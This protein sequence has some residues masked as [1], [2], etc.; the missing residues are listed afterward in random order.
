M[1][2]NWFLH[3]AVRHA[4][5]MRKHVRKLVSAQRDLLKPVA[6][7]AMDQALAELH[8]AEHGAVDGDLL[9]DRMAKVEAAANK[10]LRPYPHAGFR[11]NIEVLLVAI[12]VAMGI[13]T[14]VLQPFK[15]PTGS[16]QPTLYG[17]TDENLIHQP[18]TPIPHRLSPGRFFDF[19]FNGV[20][21]THM[22]AAGDGR[23]EILDDNPSRFLLFNLKQRFSIGGKIQT[24][25]FPPEKLWERAG[26][27][28][29]TGFSATRHFKTGED[30]I[31][32]R[33]VSGDHLFVDRMTYNF[34]R[35]R[36]GEI[37]VFETR[38]IRGLPQDQY[39]NKRMVAMDG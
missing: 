22:V 27:R 36:R 7:E 18:D 25:W 29:P 12:A 37:I 21:Y 33:T 3:R 9:K 5:Q 23:F 11:E 16:M 26:L 14:F 30:V 32:L 34:R 28:D 6:I 35:P 15:I 2:L 20:G 17:I 19:W 10:F 1:N 31:R 4:T 8:A 24:V 13:R 38:G 39:Y